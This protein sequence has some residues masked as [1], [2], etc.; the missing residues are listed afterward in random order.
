MTRPL[1]ERL[2]YAAHDRLLILHAD[3]VGVCES[4]VSAWRE[5]VDFGLLT[6]ASTMAPCG[7]FPAAAALA[8]ELGPRA[9][10]GLHFTLNSERELYRWG[11]ITGNDPESGLVDADGYF[12]PRAKPTHQ[13]AKPVAVRRELEAQ[14]ARATRVGGA[15]LDL[16]HFDSHMLTLW[17]PALMPIFI[18]LAVQ[19]AQPALI[20]RYNA[21]QIAAQCVLDIEAATQIETQILAAEAAGQV[22]LIESWEVLPFN[23]YTDFPER[24]D[25]ACNYLDTLGAGV[26]CLVGHPANDTPELR[27]FAP[28]WPTRTG[29]RALLGSDE[30]R[31][32]ITE[33]GFKL[34]GMREIR[35]LLRG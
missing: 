13:H 2:G 34:I 25:W 23:R 20:P 8:R 5:L 15:G 35:D 6:S 24:L 27:A 19:H 11:P 9:D 21:A 1:H 29:D 31:E 33:R 14:I 3:D 22:L 7:W 4:S 28:D 16:T 26:H 32:A 10:L 17:H 18:E 12:H 30:L